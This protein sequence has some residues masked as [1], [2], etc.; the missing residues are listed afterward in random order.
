MT[1]ISFTIYDSTGETI[2]NV[3]LSAGWDIMMKWQMNVCFQL[4]R[5]RNEV[6]QGEIRMLFT[7]YRC[8]FVF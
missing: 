7:F 5:M 4:L 2:F 8:N 1:R 3:N 6:G